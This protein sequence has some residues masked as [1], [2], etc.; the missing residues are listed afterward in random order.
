MLHLHKKE[1]KNSKNGYRNKLISYNCESGH[2]EAEPVHD[3]FGNS[4]ITDA[5]DVFAHVLSGGDE[6]RCHQ[7]KEA[8]QPVV[9]PEDPVVDGEPRRTDREILAD[10]I[11]DP[12]HPGAASSGAAHRG[13][14]LRWWIFVALRE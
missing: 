14:P 6:H 12:Q 13:P 8:G 1:K 11:E 3:V 7:V 5:T 2:D 10:A 4:I 9:Q